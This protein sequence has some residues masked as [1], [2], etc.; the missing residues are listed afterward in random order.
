MKSADILTDNTVVI[1]E[2]TRET[3]ETS[4]YICYFK[5]KLGDGY[6]VTVKSWYR[7]KERLEFSFIAK[8]DSKFTDV[9]KSIIAK[10]MVH[11]RETKK[12][13][14][15]HG[16]YELELGVDPNV[17]SLLIDKS[18]DFDDEHSLVTGNEINCIALRG[19]QVT[20]LD[21]TINESTM[22]LTIIGDSFV[23]TLPFQEKRLKSVIDSII[24]GMV[25]EGIKPQLFTVPIEDG[26]KKYFATYSGVDDYFL[27]CIH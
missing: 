26:I 6:E 19:D 13:T 17:P 24:K 10:L 20:P 1:F 8:T 11:G 4:I 15:K 3:S 25:Y 16:V 22:T 23:K 7:E 18:V 14:V 5:Y 27:M 2:T 12:I 9:I 21:I